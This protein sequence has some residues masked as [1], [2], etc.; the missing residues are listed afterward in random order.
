MTIASVLAA[1][2]G[3]GA[4]ISGV[5]YLIKRFSKTQEQAGDDIDQDISKE[6]DAIHKGGRPQW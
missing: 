2:A 6:K 4:V 5:V 3:A 1:I